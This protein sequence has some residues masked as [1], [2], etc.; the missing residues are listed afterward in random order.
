MKVV[1]QFDLPKDESEFHLA[2]NGRKFHTCLWDLNE[3][4]RQ[5]I[6]YQNKPGLQEARDLLHE[7]LHRERAN[8]DLEGA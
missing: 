7:I 8:L 2:K 5:R 1:L 6:E 4:L 3:E